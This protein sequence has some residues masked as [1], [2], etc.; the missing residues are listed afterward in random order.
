MAHSERLVFATRCR[1]CGG[2]IETGTPLENLSWDP[3]R[4]YWADFSLR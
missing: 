3:E 1:L 2:E 4:R